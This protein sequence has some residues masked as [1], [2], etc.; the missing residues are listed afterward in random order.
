MMGG[1]TSTHR[2]AAVSDAATVSA[3]VD[4]L[5]QA[6]GAAEE[7]AVLLRAQQDA[8]NKRIQL[9]VAE[10]RVSAEVQRAD[11]ER[12]RADALTGELDE[13]MQ[14][15]EALLARIRAL[16]Q[17]AAG[18]AGAVESAGA[19][20]RGGAASSSCKELEAA[21]ASSSSWEPGVG[22]EPADACF[23]EVRQWQYVHL[24]RWRNYDD[25]NAKLNAAEAA[26]QK[27]LVLEIEIAQGG[28]KVRNN[29][30]VDL[31]A[32]TQTQSKTL[33]MRDVRCVAQLVEESAPDFLRSIPT[34]VL[35]RDVSAVV[36]G[37]HTHVEAPQ[38]QQAGCKALMSMTTTSDS[39]RVKIEQSGELEAIF[40]AMRVHG[41]ASGVQEQA[42]RALRR[43]FHL[44][45]AA[46]SAAAREKQKAVLRHH[47][48]KLILRTLQ[49]HPQNSSICYEV[50]AVV[51][52]LAN[53]DAR[54]VAQACGALRFLGENIE[55]VHLIKHACLI[56]GLKWVTWA[57]RTARHTRAH[58]HSCAY[59]PN[60]CDSFIN[61]RVAL[62]RTTLREL[63]KKK[64]PSPLPLLCSLPS[65]PPLFSP[66]P[67]PPAAKDAHVRVAIAASGGREL[68]HHAIAASVATPECKNGASSCSN[69]S[70]SR[71]RR[72]R[73]SGGATLT[74]SRLRAVRRS[75]GSVAPCA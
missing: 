56:S 67:S 17:A 52:I 48:I 8:Q 66:I 54:M 18:G 19:V 32:K 55:F 61:F 40:A 28:K 43:M 37:M 75:R 6:L 15:E 5:E 68:I 70:R 11:A 3:R 35:Q 30:E 47:G 63:K 21:P 25:S 53:S 73:R 13:Q 74:R 64:Q 22:E 57:H 1:G 46:R 12:A 41:A 65:P 9:A 50:C 33:N 51:R 60:T 23:G 27:K 7:R 58:E 45:A 24:Q 71:R 4:E 26:G 16:E 39:V 20:E 72:R 2:R 44:G 36:E 62:P 42:C 69:S 34:L 31:D 49:G 14:L 29:Y 10:L 59:A 38:V